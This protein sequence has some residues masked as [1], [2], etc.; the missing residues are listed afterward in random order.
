MV[1]PRQ[2]RDD[3]AEVLARGANRLADAVKSGEE[4]EIAL[5]LDAW[6]RVTDCLRKPKRGG[7][8]ATSK[9]LARALRKELANEQTAAFREELVTGAR[10]YAPSDAESKRIA[11]ADSLV[12]RG[13]RSRAAKILRTDE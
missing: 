3:W 12:R 11:R 9:S 2:N 10:V 4:M 7:W 1:V 13:W 6:L 8:N 5:D